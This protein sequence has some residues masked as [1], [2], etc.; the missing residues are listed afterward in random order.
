MK[1]LKVVACCYWWLGII[2]YPFVSLYIWWM[3]LRTPLLL[4]LC[5]GYA[6]HFYASLILVCN[7]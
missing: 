6:P 4:V 1:M 3:I 7:E 2:S 5:G